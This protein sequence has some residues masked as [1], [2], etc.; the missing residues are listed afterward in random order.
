M[1]IV[2]EF[3]EEKSESYLLNNLLGYLQIDGDEDN[4][5]SQQHFREIE[6]QKKTNSS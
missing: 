1:S 4:N 6:V 2:P 5:Q 3:E